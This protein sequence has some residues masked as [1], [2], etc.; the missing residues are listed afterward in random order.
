MKSTMGKA[1]QGHFMEDK[2][3]E[4]EKQTKKENQPT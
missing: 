2:K 4:I 3:Q 1:P